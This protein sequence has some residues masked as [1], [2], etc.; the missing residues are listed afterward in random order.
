ME[1]M[2]AL[3]DRALVMRDGA[4]TGELTASQLTEE[5]IMRL[6]TISENAA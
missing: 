2:I 4:I 3:A 1:E 5:A 6:A